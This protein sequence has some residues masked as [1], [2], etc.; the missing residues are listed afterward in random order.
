MGWDRCYYGSGIIYLRPTAVP[1]AERPEQ[2]GSSMLALG[3]A[4]RRDDAAGRP[5]LAPNQHWR[6]RWRRRRHGWWGQDA[7]G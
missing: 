4:L 5:E 3:P 1:L 7:K 2:H 6:R